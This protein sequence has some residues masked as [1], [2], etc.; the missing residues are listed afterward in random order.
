MTSSG[1]GHKVLNLKER[2]VGSEVV[3]ISSSTDLD[4][5]P[6]ETTPHVAVSGPEIWKSSIK[7]LASRI[8]VDNLRTSLS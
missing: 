7:S 8:F 1:N 2:S 3:A 6:N 4:V 5:E